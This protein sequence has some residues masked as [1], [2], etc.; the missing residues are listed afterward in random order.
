MGVLLYR[1]LGLSANPFDPLG[2]PRHNRAVPY[3][4]SNRGF[5]ERVRALLRKVVRDRDPYV[6]VVIG[7][8]G[9]GKTSLLRF[10]EQEALTGR[11]LPGFEVMPAYVVAP[12]PAHPPELLLE[13]LEEA[14]ALR[15]REEGFNLSEVGW[16][17]RLVRVKTPSSGRRRMLVRL[18][19]GVEVE[20]ISLFFSELTGFLKKLGYDCLLFLVDSLED[21]VV[22]GGS[23]DRRREMGF[24][25]RL[26]DG[27]SGPVYLVAS[28]TT[29]GWS[30][31]SR[32]VDRALVRRFPA[33]SLYQVAVPRSYREFRELLEAR[34]EAF[35]L[36]GGEGIHPIS[37]DAARM[38]YHVYLSTGDIGRAMQ[39]ANLALHNAALR[40][41]SEV[42]PRDL[43]SA[44]SE[45]LEAEELLPMNYEVA[46]YKLAKAL[47]LV[48]R[49]VS[50]SGGS[51]TA[52]ITVSDGGVSATLRVKVT[53]CESAARLEHDA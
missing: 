16:P 21:R 29:E 37:E 25:R 35:R 14:V 33:G 28:F 17:I 8:V 31:V 19:E 10:L 11:L 42:A 1:R 43:L 44:S 47:S 22:H 36:H 27:L 50:S 30:V 4:I 7:D 41:A 52:E 46:V 39:L 24:L 9:Q 51:A 48:G 15:L 38:L 5:I 20:Y 6:T 40:G 34:L 2:I 32:E 49:G 23:E 26:I 13:L 45:E 18:E 3:P 53:A 12:Q